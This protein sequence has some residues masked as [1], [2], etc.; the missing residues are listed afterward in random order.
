VRACV[1]IR[2]AQLCRLSIVCAGDR[3]GTGGGAVNRP[4]KLIASA[5][6]SESEA[7]RVIDVLSAAGWACV[8]REP[9]QEMLE[10]AYWAALAENAEGVWEEMISAVDEITNP[11]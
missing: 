11:K 3:P 4:L 6:G 9:T 10:A 5:L 8:P 2:G 7:Q 1:T